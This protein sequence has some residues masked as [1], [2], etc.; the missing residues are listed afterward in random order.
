[1]LKKICIVFSLVFSLFFSINPVNARNVHIT[2]MNIQASLNEDGSAHIREV[3]NIDVNKGTE[4]YKVFNKMSPSKITGL[5]VKDETGLEYQNIGKWDTK[6]SRKE[7]AG[8]CGIVNKSNGYEICF[9]I[10]DYGEKTYTF[11]YDISH[12][13]KQYNNDQGVNFAFFS[14]LSFDIDHVLISVEAPIQL[15][16]DNANIWAYGYDGHVGFENGK[17]IMESNGSEFSGSKMQLLMRVNNGTFQN[18][19]EMNQD[20]QDVLED[21]NQGSD[22]DSEEES[23]P[24]SFLVLMIIIMIIFIGVILIIAFIAKLSKKEDYAFSD[25]AP[26]DKKNINMFRDIPCQKDIFEFY[27]LA[28][29]ANLISDKDRGGMISAI[30]LRWIK[31]GY[32]RFDKREESQMLF[33]KKDGFSIDLDR[34]IVCINRLETKLLQ[35]FKEAA[36]ENRCLETKE[37]DK[38]CSKNYE[39]IDKWFDDIDIFIESEYRRKGI[40]W[41]EI[42]HTSFMGIKLKKERDVYDVSIREEMEHVIGLSMFLKEMT[43]IVEKGVVEVEMWEYYL[44]FASILGIADK[45]QDQLGEL[46]PEFN[47]QSNLDTVYT[48]HMVHM[49]AYNSMRASTAAAQASR[50]SGYGGGASFGGGGGGFSGGGGGGVR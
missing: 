10:G 16:K 8:K 31:E 19:Y 13:V 4:I 39:K 42:C 29:K 34:D 9:G 1:M 21:A 49:F 47:Q 26:L 38:W 30:L 3:W 27:Y 18:A 2:D 48:M 5:K 24:I 12:F 37:F 23:N 17:V 25:H 32:I 41:Q 44:I 15:S 50:S 40:L 11:E 20:F 6:A 43:L 33:F 46:C 28:K 35:Y 22:Y 7:K 14:D 36:G 45:V